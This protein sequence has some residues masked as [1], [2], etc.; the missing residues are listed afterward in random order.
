MTTSSIKVGQIA[1]LTGPLSVMGRANANVARMVID[2]INTNGG[3]LG[4]PVE[5]IVEDGETTD[6]VAAAKARKLVRE[7]QVDLV[8]GGIFSS[9]RQAIK[10]PAVVEGRTLYIYPEQYEGEDFD[11][12]LFCTGPTP[13]QQLS[14]LIPW[15]LQETGAK[16][17]YLPASEY[18]WPRTMNRKVKPLVAA[19]GGAIAG[20]EYHP[21]DRTDFRDT[22]RRIMASGAEL[23]FNTIVP[24]GAAPFLEALY[25]SGFTKRGGRVVCT[26]FE[27]NLLEMFPPEHVEGFTGCLDFYEGVRDAFSK[28]LIGRYGQS[29][30]SGPKFTG[31]SACSGLYR[32][33]KLWEAAVTEAGSLD[34]D[35][36]VAALDHARIA[37]G[38]GGPAA[39]A[40]GQHH[41]R[42]NMYIAQV[43]GGAFRV[44][45]TLGAIDPGEH[46]GSESVEPERL[47]ATG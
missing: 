15:V 10:G 20:E 41:A 45:K 21:L 7:D 22:V 23:V 39:M 40:P 19:A 46:G 31:G 29:F 35:A 16:K 36:V 26:Y 42:M 17:V 4:R 34:Q 5:L 13:A 28:T 18:I 44:V 1:E 8:V 6:S 43:V 9:T 27:E 37:E 24:P 3:L 32:G 47:R 30:P 33:L 11:P 25:D 2:D 12:L 38:P 14:E